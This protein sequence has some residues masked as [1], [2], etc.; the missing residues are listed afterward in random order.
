MSESGSL[1]SH[2]FDNGLTLLGHCMPWLESAAFTLLT[3]AGAQHDPDQLPGL[4][5]LT[6]DMVQRGAGDLNSRQFV[7][8][9]DRL[10]VVRSAGVSNA[11]VRF[12]AAMPKEQLT[13]ALAVYADLLQKPLLPEEQLE[14]RR[15]VSF[16]ELHA[17]EDDL[18]HKLMQALRKRQYPAPLGRSAQGTMESVAAISYEDVCNHFQDYYS[19]RSSI[20]SV[21]GNIDWTQIVDTVGSQFQAWQPNE[22]PSLS[23]VAPPDGHEHINHESNQTHIGIV[24]PSIPYSLKNYFQLRGALGVLSDGMSSRLFTEVREKRGLCYTVYATCHT[25]KDQGCVLTYAGT[26]SERAQETLDVLIS[27]LH[28]LGDGIEK[29]ELDRLKARIKSA[30]IMQQES[31][32]SRSGT[33][34][35]EWY[36]LGQLREADELRQ[37]IDALTCESINDYLANNRPGQFKIAT[38]GKHALEVNDAVS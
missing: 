34:A 11:H 15:M 18:A 31:C 4:A 9:L 28:R 30:L 38:V 7:E 3:P 12:G 10:G 27:E 32:A 33:M 37:I 26:T 20:L 23:L 19:P 21:A 5:N 1:H 13:G 14:D 24:F 35:S 17:M 16:Q 22:E 8:A 29:H 6:C 36:L 25:L 2:T